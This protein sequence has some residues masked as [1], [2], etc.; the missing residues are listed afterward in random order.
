VTA[1]KP[2]T[3]ALISA[4]LLAGCGT[5]DQTDTGST[6]PTPTGPRVTGKPIPA[7]KPR[8][9]IKQ[10]VKRIDTTVSAGDCAAVNRLTAVSRPYDACEGLKALTVQPVSASASYGDGG[11]VIAYGSA[12]ALRNAIL[13][14][15][16]DGLYH[17]P[18]VDPVSI[19]Q[20][21]GTPFGSGFDAAAQ[22]A[23]DALR[24]HD[25]D[26]FKK[27]ALVRYGPGSTPDQICTYVD[28]SPL[29]KLL[30]TY[31]EVKP[32]RIGGNADYAFY[33][34]SSPEAHYTM[35]MVRESDSGVVPGTPSLPEDAPE[36]GFVDAYQ[37]NPTTTGAPPA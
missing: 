18:I 8:E 26:A 6:A 36:Y 33:G 28:Q 1:R 7:P 21:V 2:L 29:A 5:D 30:A 9:S 4:A 35:V 10:A 20:S 14:V 31:P 17:L 24:D 15:D 27:V 12:E 22:D 13:I 34:V 16:S 19:E 25:C 23:V 3:A 32:R 37:T 11:G